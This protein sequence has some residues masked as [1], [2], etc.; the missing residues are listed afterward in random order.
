SEPQ[1]DPEL[2]F[3]DGNVV[4]VAGSAAFRVHT[5]IL[6]LSRHSEIFQ[7]MFGVPQPALPDPSDVFDGQPV[8]HVSDSAHDFKQLLGML[9]DGAK[10]VIDIHILKLVFAINIAAVARLGHKY[11]I[12]W[13]LKEATRRLR[14]IFPD[15]H[16]DWLKNR[17][18]SN[19]LVA[20]RFLPF[21]YIE[22]V[23]LI[24]LIGETKMLPVAIYDCCRS[25]PLL[26]KGTTRVDGTAETLD[27]PT[28]G[29]CVA[30]HTK[31]IQRQSKLNADV[32]C[33]GPSERCRE[34]E[35]CRKAIEAAYNLVCRLPQFYLCGSPLH[36]GISHVLDKLE[37]EAEVC[38]FCAVSLRERERR[39]KRAVWKDLPKLL[40]VDV[41]GWDQNAE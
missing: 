30:A 15:T 36:L 21:P 25:L 28:F 3:E 38:S 35:A 11:H 18:R 10:C 23:N 27:L 12:E 39:G 14:S 33:R 17:G 22:A 6:K 32:F 4:I 7:N 40:G 24:R 19:H 2:W 5:G 16:E 31:L 1:Q 34:T 37:R 29:L 13:V 8:V 26:F 20:F 9:Y 41:D